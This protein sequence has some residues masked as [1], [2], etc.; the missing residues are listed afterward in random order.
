MIGTQPTGAVPGVVISAV[1]HEGLTVT[2]DGKPARLAIVLD[3]G[4]VVAAGTDVAREAQAVAVN[5]YRG[6][7]KGNGHLRVL[8]PSIPTGKH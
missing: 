7:L 4:T 5:L 2:V 3:D 1:A 6:F 8:S